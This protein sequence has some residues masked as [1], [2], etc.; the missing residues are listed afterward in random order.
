[1]NVPR[2]VDW[3]PDGEAVE[4]LDQT[5]LPEHEQRLLLHGAA[6]GLAAIRDMRVRGAPAIG[7]TAA[8]VLAV[9]ATRAARDTPGG[10]RREVER[11]AELLETARPTAVNLRWAL[12][13]LR[14]IVAESAARSPVETAQRLRAE[15]SAILEEDRAMCLR[16]GEHGLTLLDPLRPR[17]LTHCNAGALATG[18]IGTALAPLYVAHDVGRQVRVYA[19]ETRPLLQGSRLTVWE[20]ARAGLDVVL[21]PDSAAGI[22]LQQGA[23]DAILVGAD[24][25]A[26]NGDVANKVGTYELAVLARYH[27]VPFYVAAPTSTFDAA[28]PTGADIPIEER[29]PDE[30]RH[31][32]GDWTAPRDAAVFAPA[33]DVTPAALVDALVTDQGILR[34]PYGPGIE[35]LVAGGLQPAPE[36]A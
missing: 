9:E 19:R 10:F 27:G 31:G 35:R 30:V 7:I 6:D 22:L 16:I 12:D 36:E 21:L 32:F 1:M 3:S 26:A 5:L 15:A 28:T 18:G 29:D 23:V 4:L 34:P 13:R 24:R 20:L 33:F 11:A 8:L 2:A 14:G 25:I 17:V